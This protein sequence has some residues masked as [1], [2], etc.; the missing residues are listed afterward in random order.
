M[1]DK[2]KSEAEIKAEIG[3]LKDVK[4]GVPE[5]SMFGDSNHDKI[6]ATIAVLKE[7][8]DNDQIFDRFEKLDEEGVAEENQV[9]L[10]AALDAMYWRD[11]GGG[12]GEPPSKGWEDLAEAKKKKKA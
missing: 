5:H 9:E 3:R 1:A 6:E 11:G 12:D 4:P 2:R 7:D 8:L 10:D